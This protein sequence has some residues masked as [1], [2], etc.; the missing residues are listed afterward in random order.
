MVKSSLM[1]TSFFTNTLLCWSLVG[2]TIEPKLG[3]EFGLV[4][5]QTKF[6]HNNVFVKKLVNM[7]LDLTI[8]NIIYLYV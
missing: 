3:F 2:L 6:E 7:R 1:F 8:Y 4:V 5:K